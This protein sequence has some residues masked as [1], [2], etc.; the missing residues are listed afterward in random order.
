MVNITSCLFS[1]SRGLGGLLIEVNEDTSQLSC[2]ITNSTFTHNTASTIGQQTGGGI[3]VVF[4]GSASNN[5]VQLDGICIK[6]ND[7][8]GIL[9]AFKDEAD[10]NNV[11]MGSR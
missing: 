2:F 6:N 1:L 7:G 3:S 5:N 10:G 4:R 11:I 8:S 9:L